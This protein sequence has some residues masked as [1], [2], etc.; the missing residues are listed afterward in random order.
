[1]YFCVCVSRC[2]CILVLHSLWPASVHLV[3]LATG[4]N[5]RISLFH[6]LLPHVVSQCVCGILATLYS[7]SALKRLKLVSYA[8]RKWPLIVCLRTHVYIQTPPVS[9][10]ADSCFFI[11]TSS[12]VL[13]IH[14]HTD[15]IYFL[16]S[17]FSSHQFNPSAVWEWFDLKT[18]I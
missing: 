6:V 14:L 12:R 13:L 11:Q 15:L 16:F 9:A 17:L 10:A 3:T 4:G 5:Q 8:D 18:S 2:V 1:M 7:T